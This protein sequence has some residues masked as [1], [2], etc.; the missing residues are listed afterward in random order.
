MLKSGG[1]YEGKMTDST[2]T[3]AEK[4]G[5]APL[6]LIKIMEEAKARLEGAAPK[7]PLSFR[8]RWQ[9]QQY[10]GRVERVDGGLILKLLGDI[11][12]VPYSAENPRRRESWISLAHWRG[13]ESDYRFV[14]TKNRRLTLLAHRPIAEPLSAMSIIG[15]LAKMLLSVRPYLTLA[16]EQ[17][18]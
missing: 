9:G 17:S 12:A 1:G 3:E 4:P 10:V 8:F 11:G 16:E 13:R 15:E 18:A 5:E 6:D 7:P 14:V 2:A